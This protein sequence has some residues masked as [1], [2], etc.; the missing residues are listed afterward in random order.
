MVE[1]QQSDENTIA[2]SRRRFI[3]RNL[4]AA[5]AVASTALLARTRVARADHHHGG[6]GGNGGNGAPPPFNCFLKGT[7]IEVADGAKK[8]ED[9]VAGDRIPTLFGGL[10][11][12]QW[13]GRYKFSKSDRSKPWAKGALPVR[14]TQSAIAPNVPSADLLV[15]PGHALFLDGVL[16][17]AG[18]LVN[19][20]TITLDPAH[21][22]DVLEYFHIKLE[23]HD[24]ITAQ[25]ALVETLQ[26][27]KEHAVNFADYYREFGMPQA[28]E[29]PCAPILSYNGGVSELKSRMR[30]AMSPLI[31]RRQ[32]ID[33][34]RDRLEARAIELSA[35]PAV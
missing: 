3:G 18:S 30:S 26:T 31:D 33:V 27:V 14:V 2:E 21:E 1:Q 13:I 8:V 16:V 35:A 10:Q 12:I 29:Q 7:M 17:P 23:G 15:T 6:G 22:H 24:V 5:G 4:L 19:G 32:P 11:S 20:V 28:D 9:L 25:G 34:I